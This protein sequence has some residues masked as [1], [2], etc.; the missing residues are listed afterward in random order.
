MLAHRH[1]VR[2]RADA[3]DR[4]G[5]ESA[6][7]PA[8]TAACRTFTDRGWSL[9]RPARATTTTAGAVVDER[10]DHLDFGVPG[11]RLRARHVESAA[12]PIDAIRAGA[13]RAARAVDVAQE[14]IGAVDED[15]SV[16]LSGDREAPEDGLGERILDRPSL[17]GVAA[18]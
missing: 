2:H 4:A 12:C 15:V 8:A 13:Q 9:L 6:T 7:T 14:K 3:G 10:E 17:G 1:R 16:A 11:E 5:E 18:R